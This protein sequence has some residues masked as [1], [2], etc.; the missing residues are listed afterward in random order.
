MTTGS[1]AKDDVP[2]EGLGRAL[3]RRLLS[4]PTLTSLAIAAL[5]VLFLATRFDFDWAKAWSNILGMNPALYAAGLAAYYASFFLRGM[6]W[7]ILVHN[8]GMD[9]QEG[10][11]L[12]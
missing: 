1:P 9:S 10:A 11:A 2:Q 5:F 6:R 4:V 7:R 12:P 3:R 8:S